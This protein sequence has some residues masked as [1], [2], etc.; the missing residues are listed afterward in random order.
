MKLHRPVSIPINSSTLNL[1]KPY[2]DSVI[3]D[4]Q[5]DDIYFDALEDSDV[6]LD[7][8]EVNMGDFTFTSEGDIFLPFD[9]GSHEMHGLRVYR[10]IT[11]NEFNVFVSDRKD[12]EF[13]FRHEFWEPFFD[14][15]NINR[16]IYQAFA[17][18]C[19]ELNISPA[20]IK[21]AMSP[22]K[23]RLSESTKQV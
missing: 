10:D 23:P 3:R 8:F 13:V 5:D 7:E 9:Q 20:D 11:G 12:D 4:I 1:P 6:E 18:S 22:M 19:L 17:E 2:F 16:H 14:K 21:D 15:T